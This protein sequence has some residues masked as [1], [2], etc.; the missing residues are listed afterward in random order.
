VGVDAVAKSTRSRRAKKASHQTAKPY[1]GFPLTAH[2][3]GRWAK[4]HRGERFYFGPVDD[5]QGALK[6]YEREWP[7]LW[8]VERRWRKWLYRRNRNRSLNWTRF[9]R[10]LQRYPLARVRTVRSVYRHAANP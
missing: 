5:W 7:Y 4:K 8:E 10:M 9:R 3:T 1:E 2:P 6:R